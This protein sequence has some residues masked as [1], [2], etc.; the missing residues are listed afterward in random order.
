VERAVEGRHVALDSGANPPARPQPGQV[1]PPP[2]PLAAGVDA[3]PVRDEVLSC[4]ELVIEPVTGWRRSDGR[5]GCAE[6]A[7][8]RDAD[9]CELSAGW[10]FL[11]PHDGSPRHSPSQ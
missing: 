11:N 3:E 6:T 1:K 2:P 7:F 10:I 5:A 9:R 4:V 8:A